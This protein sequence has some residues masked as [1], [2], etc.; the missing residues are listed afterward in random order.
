MPQLLFHDPG[1]LVRAVA[2]DIF[3]G[4][5]GHQAASVLDR[6]KRIAIKNNGD[7]CYE[8]EYRLGD[9]SDFQSLEIV[10]A[11]QPTKSHR[12]VRLPVI[13]LL[14]AYRLSPY[15]RASS[16]RLIRCFTRLYFPRLVGNPSLSAIHRFFGNDNNFVGV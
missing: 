9:R 14:F 15:D 3:R 7:G 11:C 6:A 13:N 16:Q 12:C 1:H 4:E 2:D 5:L 8:A 10:K